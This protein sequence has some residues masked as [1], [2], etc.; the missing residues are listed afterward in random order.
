MKNLRQIDAILSDST[1]TVFG[2][3]LP[4]AS[5]IVVAAKTGTTNEWL[6]LD[7]GYLGLVAGVWAKQRR[8]P[9][10]QAP[11]A[12]LSLPHLADHGSSAGQR[13]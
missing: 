8:S 13:H 9:M 6:M 5:T 7:V 4:C 10:A 12:S 11:M 1:R 3:T 2:S